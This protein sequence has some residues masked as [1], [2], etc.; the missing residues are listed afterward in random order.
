MPPRTEPMEEERRLAY[1]GITRAKRRLHLTHA[2][3]RVF[4]GMGQLS[5]PSRF[6][7]EIPAELMEGPLLV[8]GGGAAGPLDLDLVFGRRGGPAHRRRAAG[9]QPRTGQGSGRPGAPARRTSGRR[10]TWPPSGRRSRPARRRGA[11]APVHAP[12][13]H[14]GVGR[15]RAT[16]RLSPPPPDADDLPVRRLDARGA[17][18]RPPAPVAPGH[19]RRAALPRRRPRPPRPLRRR[20][21]RELASSP[22]PTRRS[23]SPS[24]DPSVGR[25]TMLASLAGLDLLGLDGRRVRYAA[26]A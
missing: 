20:D 4:R 13:G 6:L 5:I 22:A 21:R 9:R 1:V 7:L 12:P 8:E 26:R 16:T 19:P 24:R 2:S 18:S 10:A 14:P 11:S 23:P 17:A 3:R 25:K 15:R